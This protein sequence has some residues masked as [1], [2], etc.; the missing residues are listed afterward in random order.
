MKIISFTKAIWRALW[1]LGVASVS[2]AV[3]ADVP[4]GR[5]FELKKSQPSFADY[6]TGIG[7]GVFWANT[8]LEVNNQKTLFCMPN[9]LSLDKGIILS[10][11]DQEIRSPSSGRQWKE[12]TPVELIM[13]VAFQ[14]RF[15]C[16]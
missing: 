15:P 14:K 10:L 7:R 2:S 5:Y 6:L 3:F 4:V 9:N 11:I 13:V 12:D 16:K 1:L 8:V